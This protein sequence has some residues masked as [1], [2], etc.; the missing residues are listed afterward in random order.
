[1]RP[2]KKGLPERHSDLRSFKKGLT[3]RRSDLRP[4]KKGLLERRSDLRTF[5]KGLPERRSDL[6]PF[7]KGLPERRSGAFR[8]KNTPAVFYIKTLHF[9]DSSKIFSFALFSGYAIILS[10]LSIFSFF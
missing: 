8:H 2:F 7:K 10:S 9:L 4:F 1:L 3:E 6:R 5:K